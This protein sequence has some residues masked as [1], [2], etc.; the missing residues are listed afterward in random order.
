MIGLV[1][2]L[3]SCLSWHTHAFNLKRAS[4]WRALETSVGSLCY[5]RTA[6]GFQ[7][8]C[9]TWVLLILTLILF[10][11]RTWS[12]SIIEGK[13]V[14]TWSIVGALRILFE[15]HR[16]CKGISIFIEVGIALLSSIQFWVLWTRSHHLVHTLLLLC[17][18]EMKLVTHE[19]ALH[20]WLFLI[21]NVVLL[22]FEEKELVLSLLLAGLSSNYGCLLAER[23][24]EGNRPLNEGSGRV[25]R[26]Y[27]SAKEGGCNVSL[28]VWMIW[29]CVHMILVIV[30]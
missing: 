3:Q 1:L 24:A 16:R 20:R 12:L 15:L 6:Y 11:R 14:K 19:G 4:I 18:M 5:H 7:K 23:R 2:I 13:W 26:L 22:L 25:N 27:F 8:I 17:L 9:W 10:A 29:V 28:V 30:W 21:F